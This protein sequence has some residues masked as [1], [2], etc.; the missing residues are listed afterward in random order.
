MTFTLTTFYRIPRPPQAPN[1]RLGPQQQLPAP[2]SPRPLLSQASCSA[3]VFKLSR[4]MQGCSCCVL[5]RHFSALPETGSMIGR[6]PVIAPPTLQDSPALGRRNSLSEPCHPQSLAVGPG[7]TP[8]VLFRCVLGIGVF[9][10][11][12]TPSLI[13]WGH[14]V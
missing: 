5:I 4:A 12:K 8:R 6:L 10:R 9:R 11:I 1:P 7:S 14:L 13:F 3:T 2:R